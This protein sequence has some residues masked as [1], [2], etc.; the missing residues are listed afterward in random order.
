MLDKIK[1]KFKIILIMGVVLSITIIAN[2]AISDHLLKDEL[3]KAFSKEVL[4]TTRGL[5]AQV[6]RMLYAGIDITKID[7]FD[8]QSI[9]AFEETENLKFAITFDLDGNILFHSGINCDKMLE[10]IVSNIRNLDVIDGV[11]DTIECNNEEYYICSLPITVRGETNSYIVAGYCSKSYEG[12]VKFFSL[13]TFVIAIVILLIAM[14][15]SIYLLNR[16]ITKPLIKLHKATKDILVNGMEGVSEVE[17]SQKDEIGKLADSYNQMIDYIRLSTVSKSYLSNIISNISDA[18][19]V[20]DANLCIETVN[21]ATKKMFGYT[22]EELIGSSVS[23]F[24]PQIQEQ[25]VEHWKNTIITHRQYSDYEVIIHSK[26]KNAIPV[27]IS[28]TVMTEENSGQVHFVCI[29]KDI[30]E[31]KKSEESI[32]YQAN[33]DM[34]TGL[35]NRY[36]LENKIQACSKMILFYPEEMSMFLFLDLDKFKIVND[37]C[38]HHAG[39]EL[40]KHLSLMMKQNLR[41]QDTLARI[42][43]D[44]FGVLLNGISQEEGLKIAEDLCEL[45]KKFRFIWE[46]K[47][48]TLGVSIG[49]VI[50]NK[51]LYEVPKVISAADQACYISK[52]KGGNRVQLFSESEQEFSLREEE[53]QVMPS[54]TKAFE[55]NRFLLVYQDIVRVSDTV[56]VGYEALIR[57][58]DEQGQLVSPGTFLPAAQRYNKLTDID[59]WVITN[60]C[61]NYASRQNDSIENDF[62]YN[63]NISATSVNA[64]GFLEFI[65]YQFEQYQV[66]P[67]RV[68]FEITETSA[69]SNFVKAKDFIQEL[70]KLGCRFALDDFGSGLSSFTYLK[71]LPVDYIKIDGVIV[72]DIDTNKIDYALVSSI[73]EIAHLMGM[74]T[75]AEYVESEAIFN[76]LR[77]IGVDYA[78]GFWVGEPKWL[79]NMV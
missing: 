35:S 27:L 43:G 55:E 2:Y 9:A 76:C 19:V 41:E 56:L 73:N 46:E 17:I 65:C 69:V 1:I 18:L 71:Y 63:I 14:A 7:E 40:I 16:W 12:P 78:Q 28:S 23:I 51:D 75:I 10:N 3:T 58:K 21:E 45:V 32:R 64:E 5:R 15:I 79:P 24:F 34:L 48:F 44:E 72:N 50:I 62:I 68:C 4:S 37:V 25:V 66:Q 6:V 57:L 26:G 42:G 36:A 39:D 77:E 61:K 60:F 30:S 67:Q 13:S 29:A 11:I 31:R 22:E 70:K 33:H 47:V 49:A 59:R 8:E 38:G 54:I 53:M 20:T 52:E 74:K